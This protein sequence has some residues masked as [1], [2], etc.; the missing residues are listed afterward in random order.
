MLHALETHLAL[1]MLGSAREACGPPGKSPSL[2]RNIYICCLFV[3]WPRS[4]VIWA[5]PK[6]HVLVG[7]GHCSASSAS[8]RGLL[9]GFV[10][11]IRM[12]TKNVQTT[13]LQS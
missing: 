6:V 13:S 2:P 12:L 3:P 11:E 1:R 9:S 8:G 7:I 4:F 5:F 10:M